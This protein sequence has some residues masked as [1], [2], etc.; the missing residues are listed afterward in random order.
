VSVDHDTLAF[1]ESILNDYDT[2]VAISRMNR[3]DLG[4]TFANAIHE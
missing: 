1:C 4:T 2:L 3:Y